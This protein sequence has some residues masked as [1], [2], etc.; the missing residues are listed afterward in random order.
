MI[1]I[2]NI[3]NNLFLTK[4]KKKKTPKIAIFTTDVVPL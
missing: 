1:K 3:K 2:Q 4:K